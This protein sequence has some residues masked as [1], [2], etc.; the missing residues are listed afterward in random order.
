M[1]TTMFG[2]LV[3]ANGR[4][5]T[6]LARIAAFALAIIAV[7]T[8]GDVIGRFFFHAPFAFTVELTQMAMALVVYFGVGLVTHEDA[9]ISADVVT[10]RLPPWLRAV[11]ALV[12]NMLA[13]GFLAVM[14]WRLWLQA[15]FLLA[16]GDTTMVW[17]VP[18]W[19]VAFAVAAGSVLFLTGM[20]LHLIAAWMALS[21]PQRAATATP[22]PQPY[23]D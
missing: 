11:F 5:A 22:V 21:N 3:R 16:K 14:V 9:H 8:F 10:L 17:T 2:V 12:T 15:E 18:L 1:T 13:L 19:P 7:V 20:L 23:R 4:V 6:L